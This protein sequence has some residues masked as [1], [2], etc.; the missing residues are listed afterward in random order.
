MVSYAETGYQDVMQDK[1]L[2]TININIPL[3]ADIFIELIQMILIA[4]LQ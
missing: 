1:W 2:Q 3:Q 4:L